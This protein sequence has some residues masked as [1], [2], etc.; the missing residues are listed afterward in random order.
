MSEDIP[1]PV[2]T[3]VPGAAA[4]I[5]DITGHGGGACRRCSMIDPFFEQICR[6]NTLQPHIIRQLQRHI[7]TVTEPQLQERQALLAENE[8]LKAEIAKLKARKVREVA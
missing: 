8:D 2:P 5:L 6:A 4:G 3:A 7:M 1:T